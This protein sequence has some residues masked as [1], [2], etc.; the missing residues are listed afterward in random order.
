MFP[1]LHASGMLL[2][3]LEGE[4]VLQVLSR[5]EA[6]VGCPRRC[7]RQGRSCR[8][9]T[10]RELGFSPREADV[11]C[12]RRFTAAGTLASNF[13]GERALQALARRETDA[14][15]YHRCR[16]MKP[17]L[18]VEG[19]LARRT[20]AGLGGFP[21]RPA[22]ETYLLWSC[23]GGIVRASSRRSRELNRLFPKGR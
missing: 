7:M 6:D 9:P 10:V 2:S 21:C 22:T 4:G 1:S 23:R 13:E 19:A 15:C 18:V 14:E 16:R 12:P 17:V 3:L 5:R 11:G 8:F 20:G